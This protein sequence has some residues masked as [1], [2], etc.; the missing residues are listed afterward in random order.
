MVRAAQPGHKDD[1]CDENGDSTVYCRSV[2]R[3]DVT[4]GVGAGTWSEK[5]TENA[6]T[7]F[8]CPANTLMTGRRDDCGNKS[9][10]RKCDESGTTQYFCAGLTRN[11]IAVAIDANSGA[12]TQAIVESTSEFVCPDGRQLNGRQ[13]SG[14][15]NG[16]TRYHC[17]EFPAN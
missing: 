15:E 11:N 10:G 13:H 12:W 16:P 2:V 7:K 6:G 17:L 4:Y 3:G 9:S 14:D 5:V 8:L 1:H